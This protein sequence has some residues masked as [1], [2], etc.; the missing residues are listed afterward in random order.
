[1]VKYFLILVYRDCNKWIAVPNDR[2]EAP[3]VGG[4]VAATMGGTNPAL[5]NCLVPEQ[6]CIPHGG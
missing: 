6:T 3:E 2:I 4:S 5:Q 1:M